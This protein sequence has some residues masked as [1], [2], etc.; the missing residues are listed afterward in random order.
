MSND[1]VIVLSLGLSFERC[2]ACDRLART[3]ASV[4]G[5]FGPKLEWSNYCPTWPMFVEHEAVKVGARSNISI[6]RCRR[7]QVKVTQPEFAIHQAITATVHN[8]NP[9]NNEPHS[10]HYDSSSLRRS[11]PARRRLGRR[12]DSISKCWASEIQWLA[13]AVRG[14]TA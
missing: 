12:A 9:S 11:Q 5:N 8:Y 2:A 1:V 10:N 4:I 3:P 14:E 13:R 7:W 6:Y